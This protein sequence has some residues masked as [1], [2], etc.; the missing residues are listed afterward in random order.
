MKIKYTYFQFEKDLKRIVNELKPNL[1][2]I[3]NIYGIPRGGI[4]LATHLSYRTGK[5][6]L[7]NKNKIDRNTLVVD[8]I[9]DSGRTL[10]ETLRDK[11]CFRVISIFTTPHT[12]FPPNF[13]CRIKKKTDWV[14]FPWET[15]ESSKYDRI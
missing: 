12:K 7:F 5:P 3:K 11:K 2:S 14:I 10:K 15:R 9:S 1:R 4:V 8:D 13:F 6:L